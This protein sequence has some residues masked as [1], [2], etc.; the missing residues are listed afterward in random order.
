V[1]VPKLRFPEFAETWKEFRVAAVLE[2]VEKPVT[3]DVDKLY[4]QIG[5]RSHGRGIFHKD[6]VTGKELGEKRVFYVVPNS[7]V[8][9]IVF[10]WEQAVAIATEAELGFVASHR[11]PMFVEKNEKSYLPFLRALF[12]RKR[13]KQLL[14]L[15]SPGGAG[16]NKTLGQQEFLKLRIQLPSRKEQKK[17]AACLEVVDAKIAA[18]GAAVSGLETYKRGL[19]Q[20]LFSQRLR[21]TKP[22]GTAFPDWEEKRLGE[23]LHEHKSK[24]TGKELVF[25]VSVHK[26]LVNQIEHLGRSFS[27]ATTDHYN[28][29]NPHDIVYTK[30]PTG[31]FPFGIIKQSH[32]END[33]I[34]SPLY[35][36][37][38]PETPALGYMLHSYFE[39]SVNV[40]N[41]LSPIVQKGAKNTINITNAGF[42]SNILNL[43]TSHTEQQK[44]ADAFAAMNAKI[45]AA[46]S[47]VS[48]METFKKGLLQQMFV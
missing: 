18:L 45:Q 32:V 8:L 46:T 38:T 5:V 23:V 11:F 44:I 48:K 34:V 27:A 10:A 47:Q 17:I 37:F 19:V 39:S 7:L 33:V 14:E 6:V 26:G 42:L 43:P 20:A 41:Y 12:L 28:R 2:R 30:S 4:S 24:S 29:V 3:I 9:N 21:F 22:D 25:S 1:S 36:V 31:D 16:R 40:S 15:A 35:G 13:G